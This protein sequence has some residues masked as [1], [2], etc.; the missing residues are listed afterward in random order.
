MRKEYDTIIELENGFVIILRNADIYC[1]SLSIDTILQENGIITEIESDAI[2][3][4][5]IRPSDLTKV[6]SFR[7]S[8]LEDLF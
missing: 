7:K 2:K 4:I 5:N 1:T 6:E 3:K 8:T